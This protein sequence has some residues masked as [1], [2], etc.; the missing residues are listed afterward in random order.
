MS[1]PEIDP[2][3]LDLTTDPYAQH[4]TTRLLD[5]FGD[6][7]PWQRRLWDTGTVTALCE[8]DEA[9]SWRAKSVLSSGAVNWLASDII[10]LA[11]KDI[12]VGNR[13]LRSQ[14]TSTLKSGV[15]HGSRNHRT[16]RQITDMVRVGYVGRWGAAVGGPSRPSP[17]RLSRAL[18]SHLL[19]CGYSMRFLHRWVTGNV[20]ANN[21]LGEL[22][23]SAGS[24]SEHEVREFE[25][26]VPFISL[27]G[28]QLAEALPEWRNAGA[29]NEWAH[30]R[31]AKL[32]NTPMCGG[33]LYKIEARDHF[34]AGDATNETI[35]R[36]IARSSYTRKTGRG[37]KIPEPF[38]N[39][40]VWDGS[41]CH[42]VALQPPGRGAFVLSL[43]TEKQV[44]N[45]SRPTALD[46]ALELAA[47]LNYGS[48]GPAISGGW[49]AIE[50][51]LIA[52][53]DNEDTKEGRGAVAADRM[54]ALV[55]CSWPRGELTSLSHKHAPNTPD[56]LALE[57]GNVSTNRER[58]VLVAD[59]LKSGRSLELTRPSDIAAAQRMQS[60]VN[61]PRSTL[62][63]VTKH[64][65]TAL[66]RLYR[67]R[68]LLMHGGSTNSVA[69][70]ATLRTAAPLVG[71]GLDRIIHASLN[72]GV[73]PLSLAS[74][75]LLNL[76]LVGGDDG[77]H[78]ADLL[79]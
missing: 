57:L 22:L 36:I 43:Q 70:Q 55:S 76:R 56:R 33:F 19:D 63:D 27:P 62:G 2:A 74:R 4:I 79:E 11:G 9:S 23:D 29:L 35:D 21:S 25:V 42:E 17:E 8:L 16:L 66:R 40:W 14:L 30:K 20:Y 50:A 75:A 73:D 78:L 6:T 44:Y 71:A 3:T 12:G 37:A 5:F 38:G 1:K 64:V 68:N 65:T 26:M 32:T 7:S 69:L 18:A 53:G 24:L 51:L 46:D 59:A 48:P 60:L 15:P 47:P 45:V 58:A 39:V 13:E 61:N 10:R 54:A 28:M 77:R 72:D 52:P 34:G 67:Q 41:E 31:A 49:A